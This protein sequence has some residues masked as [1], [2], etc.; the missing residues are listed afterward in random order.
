LHYLR[1]IRVAFRITPR[2]FSIERTQ[3]GC[4]IKTDAI[5]QRKRNICPTL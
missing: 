2:P 4:L 1:V 5:N 3:V